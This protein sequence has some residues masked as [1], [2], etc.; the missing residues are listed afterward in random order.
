MGLTLSEVKE[1]SAKTVLK[2]ATAASLLFPD[3]PALNYLKSARDAISMAIHAVEKNEPPTDHI[4]V[5][6][7]KHFEGFGKSLREKEAMEL[8]LPGGTAVSH[9]TRET[10]KKLLLVSEQVKT[11]TENATV[12]GHVS[13]VDQKRE[14]FEILTIFGNTVSGRIEE[15]HRMLLVDALRDFKSRLPVRIDGVGVFNRTGKLK[16]LKS[17]THMSVI[18]P[19]DISMRIA[20]LKSLQAGW[21]DGVGESLDADGLDWLEDS[22]IAAFTNAP[23][24]K[25]S[26]TEEGGVI[27]E[28]IGPDSHF[29]VEINLLE[30]SGEWSL[31][32]RSS[33]EYLEG[34]FDLDDAFAWRVIVQMSKQFKGRD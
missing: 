29:D 24:P 17:V 2:L 5:H 3:I 32:N 23:I 4:P 14:S 20:E 1:G 9:L 33:G 16:E 34:L 27:C 6:L 28:W 7:L 19:L 8:P 11:Y 22:L 13:E 10:R 15:E 25:L 21:L 31:L 18:D 12:F 30:H 26:P